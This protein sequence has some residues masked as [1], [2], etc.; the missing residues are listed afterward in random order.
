[1]KISTTHQRFGD[2]LDN[3]ERTLEFLGPNWRDVLNFWLYLDTL[4]PEQIL[5][6]SDRYWALD[7]ADFAFADSLAWNAA[8]GATSIEK[9][10]RIFDAVAGNDSSLATMELVGVHKILEQ[11]KSLT[12]VPLFLNL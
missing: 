8:R 11:G 6:L 5:I 3:Q 2:N 4:G 10:S 12:F 7:A 1:M 9:A